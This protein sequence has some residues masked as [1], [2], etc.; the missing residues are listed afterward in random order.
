MCF[1]C[2]G[3]LL[4]MWCGRWQLTLPMMA[5]PGQLC[6]EELAMLH[7]TAVTKLYIATPGMPQTC[8]KDGAIFQ[9]HIN[10]SGSL[11]GVLNAWIYGELYENLS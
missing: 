6:G 3:L 11:R 2:A 10:A 1:L 5:P 8:R 9:I 4:R 7:L